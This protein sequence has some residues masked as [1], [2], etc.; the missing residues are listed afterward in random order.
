[1]LRGADLREPSTDPNLTLDHR[2]ADATLAVGEL[3]LELATV[4]AAALVMHAQTW[5][6][7]LISASRSTAPPRWHS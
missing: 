2:S 4:P 3:G 5:S 1:M 6:A 7:E